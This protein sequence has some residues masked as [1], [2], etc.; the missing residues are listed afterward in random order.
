MESCQMLLKESSGPEK[1]KHTANIGMS[2]ISDRNVGF[3]VLQQ[4]QQQ[5]WLSYQL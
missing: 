2:A 1:R 3:T 4:Q 5:H